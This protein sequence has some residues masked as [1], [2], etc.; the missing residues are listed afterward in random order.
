[1][2]RDTHVLEFTVGQGD[3]ARMTLAA[4]DGVISSL[5]FEIPAVNLSQADV[6]TI[7]AKYSELHA[8]AVENG[9]SWPG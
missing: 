2:R 7:T 3:L 9:Y 8:I 6:A 5:I 4:A 1:M